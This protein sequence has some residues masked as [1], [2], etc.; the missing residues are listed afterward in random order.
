MTLET[1]TP[2]V[3]QYGYWMLLAVGFIEYVGV[4]V[5]SMPVLVVAGAMTAVGALALVPAVAF[6]V[7]GGLLGDAVW[8]GVARLRGQRIVNRVCGITSNPRACVYG[9]TRRIER[10]G[11]AYIIPAK[12]IPG[13]GNLIAAASGLAGVGATTFFLTDALAL[14]LWASVY[15][16][17]GRVFAGQVE[18]GVAWL[19]GT[20]R[21]VAA[22]ALALVAV[23][24][25][26]RWVKVRRHQ[27]GHA[28]LAAAVPSG[29]SAPEGVATL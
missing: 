4:P 14:T 29:M 1:I 11:P 10:L 9:V 13:T 3:E 2:F 27:R 22:V 5:A 7:V 19:L 8:F 26:V 17:V 20:V 28:Q 6:V 24:A 25:L 21:L 16:F 18:V 12:F 23:A 15:M